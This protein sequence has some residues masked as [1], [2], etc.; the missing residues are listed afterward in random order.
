M[1]VSCVYHSEEAENQ[2][3]NMITTGSPEGRM[4]K[5]PP[6]AALPAAD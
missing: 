6:Q 1:Q 2:Y 4:G 3:M 5:V